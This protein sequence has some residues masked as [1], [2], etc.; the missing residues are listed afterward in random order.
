MNALAEKTFRPATTVSENA[1]FGEEVLSGLLRQPKRLPCKFFYDERGSRL[2]DQICG[3]EE[4][5]L[6]RTELAILQS[7]ATEIA[8]R[9]GPHCLLVE[10]GSGSSTKTRLLLDHLRAPVAY[11]PMDISREHLLRTAEGLRGRYAGLVVVPL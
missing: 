11:V 6:T 10:L 2:F 4:Y 3:L 7:H 1:G 9:C 8:A 5:Y